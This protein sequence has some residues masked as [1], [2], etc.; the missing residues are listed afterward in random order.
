MGKRFGW[1]WFGLLGVLALLS[2]CDSQKQ[3]AQAAYAQIETSVAAVRENLEKFAPAEY[4][5]LNGL[6]DQM[7]TRLNGKDYTGALQ[8]QPQIMA[9]L[10][11]ASGV[12]AKA[13]NQ[14]TTAMVGEWR[15]SAVD[16]PRM[17]TQLN[18]RIA[19][20][21]AMARL[22]ANVARDALQHV[23]ASLPD[24]TTDWNGA[25]DASRRNDVTTAVTKAQSVKKRCSEFA[26]QLGVKI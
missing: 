15:Q 26:A 17:L 3:P 25:M 10:R 1:I 23:Q 9:Q 14:L 20:L 7:K 4:E 5:Q 2:A 19:E 13:K 24:L 12:A 11:E 6:M 16:I 21:K 8:F 22:P 18:A